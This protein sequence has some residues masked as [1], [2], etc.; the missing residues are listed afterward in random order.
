[1]FGNKVPARRGLRGFGLCGVRVG[2]IVCSG[3]TRIVHNT[4]GYGNNKV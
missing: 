2:G 3:N 4:V 1:M